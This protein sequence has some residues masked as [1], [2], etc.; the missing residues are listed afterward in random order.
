MYQTRSLVRNLT[1]ERPGGVVF[2]TLLPCTLKKP[3]PPIPLEVRK[4][5]AIHRPSGD[6]FGPIQCRGSTAE[7][8]VL[9]SHRCT[10]PPESLKYRRLGTDAHTPIVMPVVE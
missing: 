6:D 9:G 4:V 5:E 3:T 10:V 2:E 8:P 1:P 7:S